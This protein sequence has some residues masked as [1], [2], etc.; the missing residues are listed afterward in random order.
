MGACQPRSFTS[1]SAELHVFRL[2]RDPRRSYASKM[3]HLAVVLL[4]ATTLAAGCIPARP[5]AP[6]L[7]PAPRVH[8]PPIQP[9]PVEAPRIEMA[10]EDDLREAVFRHQFDHNASGQQ[11]AAKVLCLQIEGKRDPSS[12]LLRRFEGNE[13]LV[14]K[15]SLC[16]FKQGSAR[17]GVQ[18]E[19]GARGLIF[20][21]DSIRR[22]GPDTA[23]V[24]GGYFEAGLSAS[25]NVYELAKEGERWVV[26][27]DTMQWIS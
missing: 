3:N 27:K 9:P 12:A 4:F 19:T 6:P 5:P 16:T 20:R 21:I 15:A 18:D 24:E 17:G 10:D 23:V 8:A 2:N 22:T 11:R 7:V 25:G 26:K 13:P 1:V 14:K